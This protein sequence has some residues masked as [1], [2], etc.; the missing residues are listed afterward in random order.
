[1]A[2]QKQLGLSN[3]SPWKRGNSPH[4][5]ERKRTPKGRQPLQRKALTDRKLK[6]ARCVKCGGDFTALEQ[7]YAKN[8]LQRWCPACVKHS[9]APFTM[10]SADKP[11][12]PK[13]YRLTCLRCGASRVVGRSP[14]GGFVCP[15]DVGH[16][17]QAE[18]VW[19]GP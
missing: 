2:K 8:P 18:P 13:A 19:S 14:R 7:A 5:G 15:A 17:V 6:R 9:H 1:M 3:R 10:L 11:V 16:P 12:L 4:K